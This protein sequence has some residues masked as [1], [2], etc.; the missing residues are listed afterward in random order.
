MN[1]GVIQIMLDYQSAKTSNQL[2]LSMVYFAIIVLLIVS[3]LSLV[4]LTY[5]QQEMRLST[6]ALQAFS[7]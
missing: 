1:K 5:R 4:Y 3:F 2:T 6:K 7:Y